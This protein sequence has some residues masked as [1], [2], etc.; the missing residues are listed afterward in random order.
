MINLHTEEAQLNTWRL[1]RDKRRKKRE[2][3]G[4]D[5]ENI[6]LRKIN[7]TNTKYK[8]IEFFVVGCCFTAN[9]VFFSF[10]F[11]KLLFSEKKNSNSTL[12]IR[13]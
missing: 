2:R 7:K 12:K 9:V 6:F 4:C 13:I 1:R 5:V 8:I 10:F 3:G 11:G